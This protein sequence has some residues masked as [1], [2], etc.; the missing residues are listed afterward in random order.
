MGKGSGCGMDSHD[1][2]GECAGEVLSK[3]IHFSCIVCTE[4]IGMDDPILVPFRERVVVHFEVVHLLGGGEFCFNGDKVFFEGLFKISPYA[5]I[6]WGLFHR[7]LLAIA[8]P[9]SCR[10]SEFE[11]REGSSNFQALVGI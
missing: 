11:M 3:S 10:G 6:G 1:F 2:I 4:A 8:C 7:N 5:E 9:F